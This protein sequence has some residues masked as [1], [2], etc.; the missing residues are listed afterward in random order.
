MVHQRT[1]TKKEPNFFWLLVK[2][3]KIQYVLYKIQ[4]FQGTPW[5]SIIATCLKKLLRTVP[6][7]NNKL[8][9]TGYINMPC[10]LTT[11]IKKV[12]HSV[13]PSKARLGAMHS[14]F[15]ARLRFITAEKCCW[16]DLFFSY[17]VKCK[18]LFYKVRKIR[19]IKQR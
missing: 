15:R 8:S 9:Y 2:D 6:L 3:M 13:P 14:H 11:T 18:S 10:I 16:K 19:S 17:K 4:N 7:G 1:F 5:A 12:M